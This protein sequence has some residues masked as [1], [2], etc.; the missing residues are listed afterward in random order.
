MFFP[1]R[2]T[3]PTL[4]AAALALLSPLLHAEPRWWKGN[5]H[6]HSLWSDG[7][8]YPEMI[9]SWYRDKGYHFLAL[10]DHN[11]LGDS[12]KWIPVNRNKGGATAFQK[13]LERF[14]EPWVE[15]RE[16]GE[17]RQVRLKR[18]DEFSNQLNQPNAFLMIP[19]EEITSRVHVNAIHSR[20]LILPYSGP[21]A[22]PGT[23]NIA[24][25][26]NHVLDRVFEQRQRTGVP[27]IAHV[28][29]PNFQW[30]ITAEDLM[31]VERMRFFEVY[32]A[33]P[34]T[35]NAGDA[36]HASTDRI[37]DIVLTE[38]LKKHSDRV[39]YGVANDDSHDYHHQPNRNSR[40]GHAW[41]MVRSEDLSAEGLIAAMEGGD[42]YAST[43]V[44][45]KE[46][47]RSNG[48][49]EIEIEPE[50][51]VNYQT[52]FIGTRR[53]HDTTSQPVTDA[54]GAP[55]PVT[56]WYSPQ[57]GAVLASVSGTRARYHLQ[58]NEIY[59][60]ARVTSSKP[61][62][63]PQTPGECERAWTQPVVPTNKP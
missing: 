53:D 48:D 33:H 61:K 43:G 47:R 1:P 13:Y 9:A 59:V 16:Q 19:A 31:Q 52:E 35:G 21:P 12:E 45:L 54:Q 27:M 50:P 40:P 39:L 15:T 20:E 38:R 5:L 46:V 23:S 58:G 51:G 34:A 29:H 11:T 37:W 63:D 18:F 57:V 41:I 10:S 62:T 49:L 7:D 8:D 36:L 17:T 4:V 3:P 32:N 42:F 2:L 6:T 22:Q 30:A 26:L 56:R 60:R 14:G 25:L 55:L 24:A 44:T 28:N